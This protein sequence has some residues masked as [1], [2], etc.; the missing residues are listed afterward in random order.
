MYKKAISFLSVFFLVGC[1]SGKKPHTIRIAAT[2]TPHAE[3]LEHIKPDLAKQ[4]I[5]LEVV[6]ISDYNVPNRALAD[7]SVEANFFQ[8]TPFLQAQIAEFHYPLAILTPV[9]IEPMGVYSKKIDNLKELREGAVISIPNDPTNEARALLLL[10]EQHLIVLKDPTNLKATIGDIV[11][12]PHEFEFHEVDAALLPR[13]LEDVD[14]AVINTNFAM[15][16]GL[17]PLKDALALEGERSP[18][19]NVIVVRDNELKDPDLQA[20]KC[21]VTTDQMR[22]WI[23]EKYRGSIIPEF[24]HAENC[25]R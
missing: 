3:I 5:D 22:A 8:H 2:T 25:K 9:H 13:T 18:F 14:V 24:S 17:S 12:N 7:G 4:G 6:V 11:S 21:I 19:V 20:L 1:S 10:Q 23:I 16:A 15:Q